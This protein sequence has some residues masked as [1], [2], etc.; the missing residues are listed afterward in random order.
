MN[1]LEILF[2]FLIHPTYALKRRDK[3]LSLSIMV[4]IAALWSSVTGNYLMTDTSVSAAVFSFRIICM[5]MMTLFLIV[6]SVSVWH[7]ISESFK[8]EGKVSEL[9]PCIC[10]SFLPYIFLTPL[11]LIIKF[12]P[13][14]ATFYWFFFQFLIVVW[15][16][17]LQISSIRTVYELNGPLA[18]LTYFV[19][20][21]VIF[22]ISLLILILALSLFFATAYQA[23]T[24]FLQL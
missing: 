9:F 22:I 23:L 24:P 18:T 20:F 2:N 1:N 3:S 4:V 12:L 11:A 15:V 17:V 7:F 14:S 21:I 10:L 6:I 8:G 5:V 19:P 13:D 16:I